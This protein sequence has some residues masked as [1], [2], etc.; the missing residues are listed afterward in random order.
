MSKRLD[1]ALSKVERAKQHIRDLDTELRAFYAT[2]PYV[3][4]A[5][6]NPETRQLIYYIVSVQDVPLSISAVAGDVLHNLRSAL[7]HLA[8]Q[9]V[10]S[11]LGRE[12]TEREARPIAFPIARSAQELETLVPGKVKGASQRAIDAIKAAKP[13]KGGNDALWLI[14]SLN[15]IDKHRVLIAAGSA[16]ESFNIGALGNAFMKERFPEGFDGVPI[17]TFN[18][19][20]RPADKLCPLKAG[21]ELFIDGPDAK[22][23]QDMDFRFHVA[24]NEPQ[25]SEPEPMLESLSQ[26]AD[27]VND[28]IRSFES[29]V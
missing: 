1:G 26:A 4:G 11:G 14:H 21:D 6:R 15:N 19:P 8:Y 22:V 9:L 18:I 5:K 20:L 12:P 3:V 2:N 7:D 16:Y 29:L 25:V 27:L 17:P 10:R 24:F 23:N 13:Y 28:L